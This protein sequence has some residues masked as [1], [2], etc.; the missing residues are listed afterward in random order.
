VT[1]LMVGVLLLRVRFGSSS[2]NMRGRGGKQNSDH[3]KKR[4]G[5]KEE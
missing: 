2:D 4:L 3:K 5:M 1:E